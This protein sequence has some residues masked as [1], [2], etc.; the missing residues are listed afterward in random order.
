MAG[1]SDTSLQYLLKPRH[2]TAQSH[3]MAQK[4]PADA[5]DAS[6]QHHIYGHQL[7]PYNHISKSLTSVPRY[8]EIVDKS[9]QITVDASDTNLQHQNNKSRYLRQ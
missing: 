7:Q 2:L 1:T 8:L 3:K 4:I 6:L 9:K 5:S